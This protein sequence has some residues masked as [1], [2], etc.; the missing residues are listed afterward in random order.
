MLG[1]YE[2]GRQTLLNNISSAYKQLLDSASKTI[3]PDVRIFN[4]GFSTIP[5]LTVAFI[6]MNGMYRNKS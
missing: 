5:K 6:Q 4:N 1:N 2:A 3:M